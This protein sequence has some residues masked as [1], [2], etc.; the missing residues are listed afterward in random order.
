MRN[1]FGS[2]VATINSEDSFLES[3]AEPIS[4]ID[5]VLRSR[6]ALVPESFFQL[7]SPLTEEQQEF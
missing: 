3:R 1:Y 5:Y 7:F 6:E 4:P 2:G